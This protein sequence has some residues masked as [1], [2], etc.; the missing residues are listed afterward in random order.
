MGN[1]FDKILY[2]RVKLKFISMFL[3][4]VLES[5]MIADAPNTQ[6]FIKFILGSIILL[7]VKY[8]PSFFFSD[9]DNFFVKD[10]DKSLNKL[11]IY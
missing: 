6:S 3:G 9:I 1:H 7:D 2:T 8:I 10:I 5:V 4:I 11:F